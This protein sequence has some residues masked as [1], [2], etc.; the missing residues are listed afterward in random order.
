MF[1]MSS[2]QPSAIELI[3][4][5][6]ILDAMPPVFARTQQHGRRSLEP[7]RRARTFCSLLRVRPMPP[8]NAAQGLESQQ[9]GGE[10]LYA[11]LS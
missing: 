8:T 11:H 5:L 1:P 10:L 7:G 9:I 3:S 6:H 2:N 4:L